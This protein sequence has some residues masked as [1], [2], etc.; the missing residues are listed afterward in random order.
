MINV[1]SQYALSSSNSNTESIR[2]KLGFT[3]HIFCFL[4]VFKTQFKGNYIN[5][6]T[7][8]PWGNGEHSMRKRKRL[9]SLCIV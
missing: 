2:T 5:K 4:V 8:I 7:L 3:L 6:N 9:S 1:L